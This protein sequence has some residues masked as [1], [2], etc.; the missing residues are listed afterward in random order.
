MLT[1]NDNVTHFLGEELT[2]AGQYGFL[3]KKR[4]GDNLIIKTEIPD[5]LL[6]RVLIPPL[7]LQI[8]LENAIK[9]NVASRTKPL[10]IQIFKEGDQLV[11][12]N[13]LQ[14]IKEKKK[15][16]GIGLSNISNR[17]RIIFGKEIEIKKTDDY[18][19]VKL[20]LI[21]SNHEDTDY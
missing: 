21:F 16:T 5:E 4:F 14:E 6:N 20:P 3:Q 18:F 7:T 12:K 2:L 15:S 10:T 9:H 1:R 8:L 11:V 19:T 13:N 17:Y